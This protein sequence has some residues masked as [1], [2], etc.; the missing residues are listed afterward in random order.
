MTPVASSP[1]DPSLDIDYPKETLNKNRSQ[2]FKTQFAEAR[3]L[4]WE[5]RVN[6]ISKIHGTLNPTAVNCSLKTTKLA[7]GCEIILKDTDPQEAVIAYI[8]GCINSAHPEECLNRLVPFV[9]ALI[10]KEII[11]DVLDL[12]LK[13]FSQCSIE[14]RAEPLRN[15]P[16]ENPKQLMVELSTQL[17]A[18][19]N[20]LKFSPFVALKC[21]A[22]H[23]QSWQ[24]VF[25]H[26]YPRLSSHQ[27]P[28]ETIRYVLK[29]LFQKH[30]RELVGDGHK[31]KEC[32]PL[33]IR[34]A[35]AEAVFRENPKFLAKHFL[36]LFLE[37]EIFYD[38]VYSKIIKNLVDD[39]AFY[40]N[41]NR[42]LTINY[43]LVVLRYLQS[44]LA[45]F[46]DALSGSQMVK[47]T[48]K[49]KAEGIPFSVDF[50]FPR[51]TPIWREIGLFEE[52][53]VLRLFKMDWDFDP[54]HLRTKHAKKHFLSL[55]DRGIT[56]KAFDALYPALVGIGNR[57]A[58]DK[59]WAKILGYR[60][61]TG[62]SGEYMVLPDPSTI[63]NRWREVLALP[64]AKDVYQKL[65]IAETEGSST[66]EEYIDLFIEHD[67]VCSLTSEFVHDNQYHIL[68][69]I[70]LIMSTSAKEY[71][72]LRA[73]VRE[74]LQ[75]A[76]LAIKNAE[77]I[78]KYKADGTMLK[79]LTI[80][81]GI[82]ADAF[83]IKDR[84]VERLQY[85]DA[86]FIGRGVL[87]TWSG[88]NGD[89]WR[90]AFKEFNINE[91]LYPAPRIQEYWDNIVKNNRSFGPEAIPYKQ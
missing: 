4:T 56:A 17:C 63:I 67:I 60:R 87:S 62:L 37:S 35:F 18:N 27:V 83:S 82:F 81:M 10:G 32:W 9:Y 16:K 30:Y 5:E 44:R 36:H 19:K 73:L 34:A 45:R 58:F 31:L 7:V 6:L 22:P 39:L 52:R 91:E 15:I 77:A 12:V 24:K 69:T 70:Q 38:P 90:R 53:G 40:L 61:L 78:E 47:I 55:K 14:L 76:Q 23:L 1:C 50:D 42:R 46:S 68:S 80:T 74:Y 3:G 54:I 66:V 29:D 8:D 86:M 43:S 13:A 84:L 57:P 49:Y 64:E 25:I 28:Y 85:M 11:G 65:T 41:I 59:E 26:C 79:I 21:C 51:D 48:R 72:D 88:E 71:T 20:F 75:K 89:N 2:S 33:S